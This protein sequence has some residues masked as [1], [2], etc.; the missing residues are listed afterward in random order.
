MDELRGLVVREPYVDWIV[1]GEK[2]WELRGSATKVR[3]PIALIAGG[4]G[5]VVGTCEL[6]DSIG[7]LT[8]EDLRKNARKLNQRP[9]DFH[10]PLYYTRTYAW[11]LANARRLPKPVSYE[12]PSGAVI[13]VKL[14]G[15]VRRAVGL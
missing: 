14:D 8:V 4:T 15:R 6:R 10:E 3:G 2:T 7:P 1:D 11:V 9:S 13:W 5:T 12:H